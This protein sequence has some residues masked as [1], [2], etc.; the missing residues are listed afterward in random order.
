MRAD[1]EGCERRRRWRRRRRWWWCN[2]GLSFGMV[3]VGKMEV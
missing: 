3:A 2:G 1:R